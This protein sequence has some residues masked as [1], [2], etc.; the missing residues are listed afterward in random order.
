MRE[1][2]A[3]DGGTVGREISSELQLLLKELGRPVTLE[4]LARR[5]QVCER[6]LMLTSRH[7]N[8]SLWAALQNK[9]A[10]SLFQ[11]PLGDRAENLERAIGCYQAALQVHT[12]EAS[13][14][15]WAITQNNL[16][17]AYA[18]RVR[19]DRAENLERAIGCYQAAL[20]VRTREASPT[21]WATT[22]HNLGSA[23]A[24]RVRGDRAENLERAIG[25]YK[26]ALGV[27]R[28]DSRP[29]DSR[30]AA[31][32]LGE[33]CS[34]VARWGEAAEAY[35]IALDA[36]EILFQ[37]SVL[38][39]SRQ[40]ELAES[41]G[42]AAGAAYALARA[43][44]VGEAMIVLERGRAR[45]LGDA[46]DRDRADLE[47]VAQREPEAYEIYRQA[48]ERLR[49]V[50]AAERWSGAAGETILAAASG[51]MEV[52][53]RARR[54]AEETLV[55]QAQA[56]IAELK[57]AVKRIRRIPRFDTFLD[58][59][60]LDKVAAAVEASAPLAYLVCTAAG[61]V[62]LLVHQP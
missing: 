47:E 29:G 5:I 50:E 49:A 53:S 14:T 54:A 42:V 61:S 28:P 12:R 26:T 20:Q 24:D 59:P 23:Y 57:G 33:V 51:V 39:S 13:P 6:A 38:V 52:G 43:G 16:G 2:P 62:T 41:V 31:R 22:Q 27:V 40:A 37:A 7:T 45:E 35:R 32:N 15:E 60:D 19:G 8:A 48:A 3:G 11:E 9:L 36:T 56:A 46:L 1:S 30:W 44:E 4:S 34:R 10:G 18:D 17:L 55:E 21:D 25:C 58:Q